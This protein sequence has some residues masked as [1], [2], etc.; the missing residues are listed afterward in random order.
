MPIQRMRIMLKDFRRSKS[1][2]IM[3]D[4]HICAQTND[5]PFPWHL[6]QAME[7]I[8]PVEVPHRLKS[9][10]KGRGHPQY[11]LPL[12][13]LLIR[14]FKIRE[15][16]LDT[17]VIGRILWLARTVVSGLAWVARTGK[18]T[19]KRPTKTG[20]SASSK[21]SL[22]SGFLSGIKRGAGPCFRP[23]LLRL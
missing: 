16:I 18:T 10:V 20:P 6:G 4:I 2:R 22:A 19:R 11:P 8:L 23:Q 1:R 5:H 3:A 13:A 21:F 15:M 12:K 17:M 7:S 14:L 9:Q